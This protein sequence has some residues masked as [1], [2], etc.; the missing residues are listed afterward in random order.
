[1]WH[2]HNGRSCDR[3]KQVTG[4]SAAPGPH[5]RELTIPGR[6]GIVAVLR[7]RLPFPL[8][9]EASMPA[10]PGLLSSEK[11]AQRRDKC[12]FTRSRESIA[13][14]KNKSHSRNLIV[15]E[16][17][18]PSESRRGRTSNPELLPAPPPSRRTEKKEDAALALQ[19]G[20]Q[21]PLGI[22]PR[23]Q[24]RR[25]MNSFRILCTD[26]YTMEPDGGD[27]RRSRRAG[28]ASRLRSPLLCRCCDSTADPEGAFGRLR[29]SPSAGSTGV[30]LLD[31]CRMVPARYPGG[32][33]QPFGYENVATPI[34]SADNMP[35]YTRT[36]KSTTLYAAREART[37]SGVPCVS[38]SSCIA[39]TP[40]VP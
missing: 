2:S 30:P 9:L 17:P 5:D 29:L 13:H 22:E 32:G 23:L 24:E 4:H 14:H 19:R 34:S 38:L 1:M 21:V 18:A 20:A 27:R 6:G 3:G 12:L 31:V 35:G 16:V 39:T 26:R 25:W 36:T 10:N 8:R 11:T 40:P 28:P 37:G 15:D 7:S 33:E